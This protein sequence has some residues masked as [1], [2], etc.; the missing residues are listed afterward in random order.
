MIYN[1]R[2]KSYHN[3]K[4]V[5]IYSK[6]F[7]KQE[8]KDKDENKELK[9][10]ENQELNKNKK[11]SKAYKNE[12]RTKE[13]E[14]HCIEY[15]IKQTKNRIYDIARSN[16]WEWFITL[17]FDRSKV[18]SNDYE[19][20]T[21][22]L[23]KF[24]HNLQQNI[25]PNIKYLIVPELHADGEHYHF[26][27]LLANC[28]GL[29]FTY[30]GHNDYKKGLPIYNIVNWK[31]GFTTATQVQDTARVS[32][33]ITKYITKDCIAVLKNKKR[34]YASHNVERPQEEYMLTTLD[35][36]VEDYACTSS[37]MKTINVPQAKMQVHYFEF[38]NKE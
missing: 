35:E 22:E 20:V 17:T 9:Q 21:K 31:L 3:G 18:F 28:D 7:E 16:H 8:K 14:E 6:S 34:Y 38:D 11:L 12:N 29:Q 36:F 27:G 23:T 32:S 33:Y 2:I 4:Q 19:I 5:T 26:H 25:C 13:Q 10:E 1:T 15:S 37:Y 24:L 30:S